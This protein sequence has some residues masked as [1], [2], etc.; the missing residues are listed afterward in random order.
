MDGIFD[1]INDYMVSGNYK[2]LVSKFSRKSNISLMDSLDNYLKSNNFNIDFKSVSQKLYSVINGVK[3]TPKCYCGEPVNYKNISLGYFDY[4]SSR[5]QV[6]SNE[7]QM[8]LK[9]TNIEKYGVNHH[10]KSDS[11]RE[12]MSKLNSDGVLGFGSDSYKKT[13]I[14]KY[15]VSNVSELDEVNDRKRETWINNWDSLSD[16]D[17]SDKLKSRSIKYSKTRKETFFNSF[18]EKWDGRY[19]ILNS[20]NYIT[21]NGFNNRGLYEILCLECGCNFEILKSSLY[22]REKSNMDICTNCNPY[23]IIT[24]NMEEE[25]SN[26][27]RD[28][29]D[30]EL[31]TNDR[32]LL[33]DKE[34]DIYLPELKTSIEFDGLYW[35]SELYKNDNYH[36]EKTNDV[37]GIG[38][39]M[40]HIFEDEWVYKKDIVKSRILNILGKSEKIYGRKCKIKEIG[41]NK[42]VRR[43]LDENHIQGYV[44]SK[45]K[46][47]L[48]YD[49]DLV[50]LMTFGNMRRNMGSKS[51]I[52]S[53]ELLRF[54]NKLN[55]SVVG[56]ASK[57]FKYFLNNYDPEYV[58]SYADRRWSDGNLYEKLNLQFIHNSEPS[59]F[60]VI[61]GIRHNRFNFRK[62]KL[63]SEGFNENK[64][65]REIM[66]ERGYYRIYDCGS[67]KYEWN[68]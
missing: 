29:Y 9:E 46:L 57:L 56:G 21:N 39:R 68:R 12:K 58:L 43:F 45:I 63:V 67:K 8:K 61:N 18:N 25:I 40:I 41:D 1:Y 19:K 37:E 14:Y 24:S 55:T 4:C 36:L 16:N 23:N 26:F 47:G 35:H 34:V 6:S 48:Y 62:D 53:Y 50:S 10:T 3:E 13:I 52:G 27:I 33:N 64:T 54:C 42:E 51:K 17:K 49:G 2:G 7:T 28:N 65:S 11:F 60:Y 20:D 30:G 5:C 15:G 66:L 38:E 44:G 22:Q 59:W 32:K 31:I